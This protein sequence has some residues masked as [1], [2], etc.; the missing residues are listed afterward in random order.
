MSQE[1]QERADII[2]RELKE[3]LVPLREAIY[4]LKTRGSRHSS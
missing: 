4:S 1:L 3:A 2:I